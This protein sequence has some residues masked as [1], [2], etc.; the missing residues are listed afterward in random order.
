MALKSITPHAG[1]ESDFKL[2]AN[3]N[4]IINWI[5][6]QAP[7]I[8]AKN[9]FNIVGLKIKNMPKI[10]YIVPSISSVLIDLNSLS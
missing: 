9:S 8:I 5:I 1:D 6:S 3:W 7:I 10:V 4:F 2:K